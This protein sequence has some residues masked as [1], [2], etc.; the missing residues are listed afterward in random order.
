MNTSQKL[1]S[2]DSDFWNIVKGIG[3]IL[4][5]VGHFWGVT[6]RF[7]Y[8][9]HL[10]LFFFV[11][12]YMYNE[13]KYGDNPYLNVAARMKS[14]WMKYVFLFW[15]LI[16]MH[17]FFLEN[18]MLWIYGDVY[19]FSDIVSKM[20]DALFGMGRESFGVTLWFVPA[21]VIATCILGF[22]VTFSRKVHKATNNIYLKYLVQAVIVV[23]CAVAGYYFEDEQ[24]YMHASMQVSLVVMPFLW[25][26][27]LLR[28][29]QVEF[30]KYLNVILSV[31][32]TV[33]IYIVSREHRLDLAMQWVYPMMHLFAF[34]GIYLSM[35]VAKVIQKLPRVNTLFVTY[36]R[37]SFWIMFAHLVLVRLF[38]WTY[39]NLFHKEDFD[40][41]YLVI[42]PAVFSKEFWPIY[43]VLGLGVS[44][45][46]FVGYEKCKAFV[47]KKCCIKKGK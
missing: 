3:I 17:N 2:V 23:A 39:I 13:E 5:V 15:I 37:A 47:L 22:V 25:G 46:M 41:L 26:G 6:T 30:K 29:F 19:S 11:S 9:F 4:V 14:S 45:L 34:L 20:T 28:T 10:P 36:G 31:I 7:V 1:K 18:K 44:L 40:K 32:F 16:W 42:K 12:G 43:L 21:S 38:D 27:Y 35:Y 8:V 33:L 24:I